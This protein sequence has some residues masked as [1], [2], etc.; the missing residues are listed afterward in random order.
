[1][2][3]PQ[4]VSGEQIKE[5]L[6]ATGGNMSAAAARVGIARNNFYKRVAGLGVDLGESRGTGLRSVRLS[7]AI[8]A[9]LREAKYDLQHRL[10]LDL[11]ES[12][13]LTMFAQEAFAGWLEQKLR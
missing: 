1:M 5:A 4:R 7:A 9:Q 13:V 10:R 11:D 6:R 2:S 8:F 3:A 12:A